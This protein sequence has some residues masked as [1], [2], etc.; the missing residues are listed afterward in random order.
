MV[1]DVEEVLFFS[2]YLSIPTYYNILITKLGCLKKWL[3][4]N[5]NYC[6]WCFVECTLNFVNKRNLV[7]LKFPL[8][9]HYG[10]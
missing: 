4:F 9:K 5:V 8:I 2:L 6:N 1:N 10:K 3:M 7:N